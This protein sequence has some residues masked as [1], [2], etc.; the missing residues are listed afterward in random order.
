MTS[1]TLEP[2]TANPAIPAIPEIATFNERGVKS[3]YP[4]AQPLT[5]FLG[6]LEMALAGYY[7]ANHPDIEPPK[8]RASMG[9]KNIRVYLVFKREG[10]LPD[11]QQ[12]FCFVAAE[13]GAL[14]KASQWSQANPSVGLGSILDDRPLRRLPAYSTT[15]SKEGSRGG[16]LEPYD[17]FPLSIAL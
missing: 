11:Y 12:V 15:Y 5:A 13:T 4:L 10:G 2:I 16:E 7:R 1:S 17:P 6:R 3:S 14:I 9:R 8:V